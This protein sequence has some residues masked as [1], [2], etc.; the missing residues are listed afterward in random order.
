MKITKS[1]I[2]EAIREVLAE[3]EV[4]E[5]LN[6]NPGYLPKSVLRDLQKLQISKSSALADASKKIMT[7]KS[8][9]DLGK[10]PVTKE[11]EVEEGWTGALA[12]GLLAKR[13]QGP[14]YPNL[15][16]DDVVKMAAGGYFGHKIQQFINRQTPKRGE[17][18]AEK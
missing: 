15:G 8:M 2:K 9:E 14:G 18:D 7:P 5:F 1:Q 3:E 4:N 6:I 12:G 13:T 16:L 11:G 17:A 10:Q